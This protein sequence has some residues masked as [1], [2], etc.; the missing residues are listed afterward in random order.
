MSKAVRDAL[1]DLCKI[2]R[3]FAIN[4][5]F[6]Y[7][8]F[9][10]DRY[11]KKTIIFRTDTLASVLTPLMIPQSPKIRIQRLYMRALQ[12]YDKPDLTESVQFSELISELHYLKLSI[13]HA[14]WPPEWPSPKWF[15]PGYCVK[16]FNTLPNTFLRP[17]C[18]T[19]KCVYLGAGLHWGW[20]PKVDFRH[21]HFPHLESLALGFFIFSHDWQLEWLLSHAKSLR[22]LRLGYCDILAFANPTPNRLD[23][24]GYLALADAGTA[25]PIRNLRRF[26]GRWCHYYRAFADALPRLRLSSLHWTPLMTWQDFFDW[27]I[28]GKDIHAVRNDEVDRFRTGTGYKAY[29]SGKF[30]RFFNPSMEIPCG[31]ESPNHWEELK[32]LQLNEDTQALL[33]LLGVI[34]K[35]NTTAL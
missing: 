14:K 11:I 7:D 2:Q 24:D 12:A 1:D 9:Q 33:G 22:Y 19:L 27:K 17:A 26:E 4:I 21:I 18:Q 16:F 31:E 32:R 23:S 10:H 8:S 3:L 6:Y 35:R 5:D 28:E 29:S 34:E 25:A 20:H 15:L 13:H 30:S